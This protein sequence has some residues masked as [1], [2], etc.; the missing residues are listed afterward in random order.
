MNRD[1]G[2]WNWDKFKEL[3]ALLDNDVLINEAKTIN[4]A[5]HD[6]E[7]LIFNINQIE[8]CT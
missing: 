4:S 5:C 3:T 8:V 1:T 2:K 6:G 7:I